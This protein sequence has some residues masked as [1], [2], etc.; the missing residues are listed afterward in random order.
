MDQEVGGSSPPSCTKRLHRSRPH[1]IL[2]MLTASVVIVAAVLPLTAVGAWFGLVPL[3]VSYYVFVGAAAI[4]YLAVV[5][6]IKPR[7]FSALASAG[8]P[9]PR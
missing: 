5:E 4:A 2:A 3:P 7:L 9:S 8:R 1:P 6:I